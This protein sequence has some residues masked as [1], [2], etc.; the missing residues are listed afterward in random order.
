MQ[1]AAGISIEE[2]ETFSAYIPDFTYELVNL[3][4]YDDI[5]EVELYETEPGMENYSFFFP[6]LHF[7]SSAPIFIQICLSLFG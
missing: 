1:V 4:K 2:G 7:E 3:R 6:I 5:F